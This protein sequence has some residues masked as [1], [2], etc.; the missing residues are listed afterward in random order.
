MIGFFGGYQQQIGPFVSN[1]RNFAGAGNRLVGTNFAGWVRLPNTYGVYQYLSSNEGNPPTRQNLRGAGDVAY[2]GDARIAFDKA[3]ASLTTDTGSVL[4]QAGVGAG[5]VYTWAPSNL[6][7]PPASRMF[8]CILHNPEYIRAISYG[9]GNYSGS[10]DY[11]NGEFRLPYVPNCEIIRLTLGTSQVAGVAVS[12]I[13]GNWPSRLKI[14]HLVQ[15]TTLLS[16]EKKFPASLKHL[17]LTANASLT[18]TNELIA[19]CTQLESLALCTEVWSYLGGS[20]STFLGTGPLQIAHIPA[21]KIFCIG[22]SLLT[23]I[24]FSNFTSMRRWS[25]T[26]SYSLNVNTFVNMLNQVLQS[27]E[28]EMVNGS[29]NN[30]AFTREFDNVDF[31]PTLRNFWLRSN[32]ITT[33]LFNLTAARPAI[34]QF[35]LG[36]FEDALLA[37]AKSNIETI[38][39][40]G[41]TQATTIDLSNCNTRNL[42]LPVNTTLQQL[43]IGGNRLQ[44]SENQNP[45][46]INQIRAMTGLTALYLSIGNSVS[47]R[48]DI[49]QDGFSLGTVN[50]DTLTS[51]TTLYTSGCGLT[52]TLTI[53]PSVTSLVAHG[54]PALTGLA[55]PSFAILAGLRVSSCSVFNQD[56]TLMPRLDSLIAQATSITQLDMSNRSTTLPL[57]VIDMV[58]NALLTSVRLPLSTASAVVDISS[59]FYLSFS[60]CVQLTNIEN[61]ENLSYTVLTG[62]TGRPFRAAGCALNIDF[63]IGINSFLPTIVSIQDNAMDA[64]HVNL[65][66][67][68]IYQNRSKWSTTIIDKTLTIGGTNAAADGVYQ[69]PDGF[70]QGVSDGTPASAK[71]QVYVLVN[72]HGWTIT[73]N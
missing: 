3:I 16:I 35:M 45:D 27:P 15:G 19:D 57:R 62:T 59:T 70:V 69:A 32:R 61:L 47:A 34:V 13:T 23:D 33:T 12:A 44:V 41:L 63:K 40:S 2:T 6:F 38:N 30:L 66:I 50:L 52:G 58:N 29:G 54:N 8:N 5:R 10:G 43:C 39:I 51:L 1:G 71:E 55:S 22:N 26:A 72:N 17:N 18:N 20:G 67:D 56:F 24:N 36:D 11:Y 53:P 37:S 9:A 64:A 25:V 21:L 73:T 42:V 7:S 14:L 60:N 49:G 31:K 28:I 46:L 68:N 4:Y 65:N 48:L